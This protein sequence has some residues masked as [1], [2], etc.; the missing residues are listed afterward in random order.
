VNCMRLALGISTEG[1]YQA[2]QCGEEPVQP[3]HPGPVAGQDNG[4]S[5]GEQEHMDEEPEITEPPV[6]R[7]IL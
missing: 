1:S 7:L 3:L 2:F 5:L 6:L 4:Q